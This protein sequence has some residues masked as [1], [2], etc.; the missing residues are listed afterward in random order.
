M[1]KQ[2][3][4]FYCAACGYVDRPI[5]RKNEKRMR[6]CPECGSHRIKKGENNL[7]GDPILPVHLR[8]KKKEKE[9]EN[10]KQETET[11]TIKMKDE[12]TPEEVMENKKRIEQLTEPESEEDTRMECDNCGEKFDEDELHELRNIDGEVEHEHLC[13]KCEDMYRSD[14]EPVATVYYDDDDDPK[15]IRTYEDDT[16]GD[17]K[18]HWHRTDG[19]RGYYDVTSDNWTAIHSDC[20]LWGSRDEAELEKFD[21]EFK[22]ALSNMGIR[23]ARV[24]SRTSNL[25]SQGYDFFVEQGKETDAEAIRVALAIRYRDPVRFNT[26]A[27]TGKDPENLTENDKLFVKA[28]E[29]LDKGMTP[30]EAVEKVMEEDA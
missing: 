30:E 24:F 11:I 2:D 20:A 7:Y 13:E 28:V 25:F 29:L 27:Y 14:D 16:E 15:Y 6:V 4:S 18:V 23:Y 22:A 19:W 10:M 12:R 8:F 17:F 26:T 3:F 1:S 9:H 21:N 5:F